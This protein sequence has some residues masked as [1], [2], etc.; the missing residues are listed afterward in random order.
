[1][2]VTPGKNSTEVCKL[3]DVLKG[4]M[5]VPYVTVG[6]YLRICLPLA[7]FWAKVSGKYVMLLRSY[8]RSEVSNEVGTGRR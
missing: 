3:Y 7:K 8:E 5:F 2:I 6:N 4:P 1:M